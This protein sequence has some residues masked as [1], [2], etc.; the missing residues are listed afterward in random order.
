MFGFYFLFLNYY[1][2][3][4]INMKLTHEEIEEFLELLND[5]DIIDQTTTFI[6]TGIDAD[7]SGLI[8]EKE[9]VKGLK[10]L[11]LELGGDEPT[12]EQIKRAINKMD[13]NKDH[14]ISRIELKSLVSN[15]RDSLKNIVE[16]LTK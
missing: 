1:N 8:D 7:S 11:F 4:L 14:K 15:F 13:T 9:F 6:F 12:K 16:N 5:P 3:L 2:Q 10:K